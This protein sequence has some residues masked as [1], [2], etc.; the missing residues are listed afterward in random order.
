LWDTH[1]KA[2]TKQHTIHKHV[3]ADRRKQGETQI[4]PRAAA[5]FRPAA[6][7]PNPQ[8]GRNTDRK[9][10]GGG[11]RVLAV[12]YAGQN[13]RSNRTENYSRREMLNVAAYSPPWFPPCSHSA[14][15]RHSDKRSRCEQGCLENWSCH[16]ITAPAGGWSYIEFNLPQ[17]RFCAISENYD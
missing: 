10:D 4:A 5:V 11:H 15:Y 14:R 12:H 8:H 7:R 13:F 3:H 16:F 6:H 9:A 17:Y 2:H 1:R